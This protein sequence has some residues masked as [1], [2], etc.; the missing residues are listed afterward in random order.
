[1]KEVELKVDRS[2]EYDLWKHDATDL[3]YHIT[4]THTPAHDM[5]DYLYCIIMW[6]KNSNLCF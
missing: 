6:F 4:K 2:G 5:T 1:M 3:N